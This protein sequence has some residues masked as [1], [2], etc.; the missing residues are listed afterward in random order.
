M[1]CTQC[2]HLFKVHRPSPLPPTSAASELATEPARW[3]VRRVDGSTH[4]LDSLA[5]LGSLIGGGQFGADD[6]I[7]RTGHI[8]KRLGEIA[9]LATMFERPARSRR[10]SEPPPQPQLPIAAAVEEAKR[11]TAS[12]RPS[13]PADAPRRRIPTDPRFQVMGAE[14]GI[15]AQRPSTPPPEPVD[16]G[17]ATA[18]HAP[19]PSTPSTPSNSPP[20]APAPPASAPAAAS[21]QP[22]APA[23]PPAQAPMPAPKPAASKPPAP[24]PPAQAAIDDAI[25]DTMFEATGRPRLRA[26][27]LLLASV[28]LLAAGVGAAVLMQTRATPSATNPSRVLLQRADAA[29]AEDKPESFQRAVGMYTQ[30]LALHADDV[31]TLASI[32]RAYAIWSESLRED[33]H[34][35]PTDPAATLADSVA[36][37][38]AQ[39]LADQA[40]QY[41]ERA[42]HRAPGAAEAAIAHGDALRLSGD[43]TAARAEIDRVRANASEPATE[44]LRVAALLAIDAAGGAAS[45]G[46]KLA[47]QAVAREPKSIRMRLLLA[48]CLLD[49]KDLDGAAQQLDAARSLDASHPRIESLARTLEALRHVKAAPGRRAQPQSPRLRRR[50]RSRHPRRNQ[51]RHP[52]RNQR[53]RP[54]SPSRSPRRKP[55]ALPTP[56]I[57]SSSCGAARRRSSAALF[58]SPRP[59]SSARSTS[60]RTWRVQRPG[61]GT[62]RSNAIKRMQRSRTSARPRNTVTPR[63]SSAW[64]TPTVASGTLARR[65]MPIKRI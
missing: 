54:Q 65:S 11:I 44:T 40:K 61:S 30:A 9:E 53:P 62:S 59:P 2:G 6:E 37:T 17:V 1:K 55:K 23:A 29:L 33:L 57:H 52:R 39:R 5:E 20:P 31:H 48:R 26:R 36:R 28:L 14:I 49:D 34:E 42:A 27:T 64:A 58:N 51:R 13:A 63:P 32:S 12:E 35:N 25:D 46:R 45:A 22:A 10:M 8:W 24:Q 3:R 43:L 7:S 56:T 41:A 15:D 18:P 19:Q 16:E 50:R 60:S 21:A 4:T 47:E 38:E